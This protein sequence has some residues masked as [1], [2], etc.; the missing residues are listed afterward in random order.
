MGVSVDIKEAWKGTD[1]GMVFG[2]GVDFPVG[3]GVM[4]LDGRYTM[5]MS[6]VPDADIEIDVKNTN[7]SFMVG[8]GF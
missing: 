2:G 4:T 7:I 8:Y 3:S 1:L 5:G 6:K